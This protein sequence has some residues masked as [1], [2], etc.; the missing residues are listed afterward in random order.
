[1]TDGIPV[2]DYLAAHAPQEVPTCFLHTPPGSEPRQPKY[3]DTEPRPEGGFSNTAIR[4]AY[5][6][7]AAQWWD[8][9]GVRLHAEYTKALA[10]WRSADV[11]ARLTQWAYAYADAMLEARRK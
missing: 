8:D 4:D 2:R 11:I 7:R 1:M 10:R 9:T 5:E 6:R 3:E